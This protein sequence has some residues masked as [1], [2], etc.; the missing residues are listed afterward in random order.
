MIL[1]DLI[2]D[3]AKI[4]TVNRTIEDLCL[5]CAGLGILCNGCPADE[6]KKSLNYLAFK[7]NETGFSVVRELEPLIENDIPSGNNLSFSD[8]IF[9]KNKI[10]LAQ[11]A[12]EDLCFNCAGAGILCNQCNIHQARRTLASLP[13]KDNEPFVK[14]AKKKESAASGGSCGTSCSTGCGTKK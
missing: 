7:G 3:R 10:L 9:E 2:F 1:E 5:S 14:K 4:L 12:V 8:L 6:A 11:N 13:V